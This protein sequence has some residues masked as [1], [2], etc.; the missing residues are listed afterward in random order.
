MRHSVALKR[1]SE[2]TAV[3]CRC[4]FYIA[5]SNVLFIAD[6]SIAN[7]R[8]KD[9]SLVVSRLVSWDCI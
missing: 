3:H 8:Y 2:R 4:T 1:W 6:K 9:K 5:V 7:Y